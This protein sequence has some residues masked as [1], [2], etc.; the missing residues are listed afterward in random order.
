M[1]VVFI[2]KPPHSLSLSRRLLPIQGQESPTSKYSDSSLGDNYSSCKDMI[3]DVKGYTSASDFDANDPLLIT[4]PG[5]ASPG[6]G[7]AAGIT[8]FSYTCIC[9]CARNGAITRACTDGTVSDRHG[10]RQ[11]CHAA[12]CLP[13]RFS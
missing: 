10:Y 3:R 5:G 11:L 9:T 1:K 12:R 6:G 2:E 8:V 4:A 13:R 7:D